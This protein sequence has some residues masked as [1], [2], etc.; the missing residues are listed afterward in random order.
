MVVS[1]G[2]GFY[3]VGSANTNR[4][5]AFQFETG[6]LNAFLFLRGTQPF[7]PFDGSY[8]VWNANNASTT[9]QKIANYRA[10]WLVR[11]VTIYAPPVAIELVNGTYTASALKITWETFESNVFNYNSNNGGSS[12]GIQDITDV[13]GKADRVAKIK[14]GLQT[15]AT[16]IISTVSLDGGT[17]L[18]YS[19]NPN[20]ADGTVS[21][22]AAITS[23]TVSYVSSVSLQY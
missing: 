14:P 3:H 12:T 7:Y 17:T 1:A 15:L 10:D 20:L 16:G 13:L 5:Q 22:A 8:D 6:V 2:M 11:A 9:N 19:A 4:T 18:L 21:T 23:I